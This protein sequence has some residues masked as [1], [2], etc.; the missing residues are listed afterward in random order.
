M[1][2]WVYVAMMASMFGGP[3]IPKEHKDSYKAIQKNLRL[4]DYWIELFS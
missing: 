3:K 2:T 1:Q 4:D